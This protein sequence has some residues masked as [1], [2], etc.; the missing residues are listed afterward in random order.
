MKTDDLDIT[1]FGKRLKL[2][3]NIFGV[4][5]KTL[6]E[7]LGL[8]H[9]YISRW[10]SG[11]H[12]PWKGRLD[13]VTRYFLISDGWLDGKGRRNAFTGTIL[14]PFIN[15]SNRFAMLARLLILDGYLPVAIAESGRSQN[16]V[17][18]VRR[19]GQYPS[20]A[21]IPTNLD[22][23]T[24]QSLWGKPIVLKGISSV[25]ITNLLASSDKETIQKISGVNVTEDKGPV[26]VFDRG[27]NYEEHNIRE[28]FDLFIRHRMSPD[29]VEEACRRYQK[30]FNKSLDLEDID[31]G[32]EREDPASG[33]V[34]EM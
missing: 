31:S 33:H 11:K 17:V 3:R 24:I 22:V 15:D 5:Q 25:E 4:S 13:T 16:R 26:R 28:A 12:K 23:D 8:E 7:V 18:I 9:F 30:H 2:L 20:S 32:D 29:A 1:T 6:G 34:P 19:T 27:S 14:M 10:E 21:F